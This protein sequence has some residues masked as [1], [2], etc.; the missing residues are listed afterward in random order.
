MPRLIRTIMVASM[1]FC[2]GTVAVGET[3]ESFVEP[4]RSVA[5]PASEMGVLAEIYVVE[6]D[7]VTKDQLVAKLNDDV[8]LASANVA[9]AAMESR[10]E[11]KL[12][13]AENDSRIDQ[14]SSYERLR[15]QGN[16]S[17]REVNRAINEKIKSA[18]KLQTARESQEVRRLEFARVQAQINLRKIKSPLSG[19]VVAIEKTVGEFVS[20]TDPVVMHI[21]ELNT[22]KVVFSVPRS[23]V[24]EIAVGQNIDL[25]VGFEAI[26]CQ[27]VVDF[28]SPIADPQ[29]GTVRVKI[30]ISNQD[31][32]LQSGSVCRWNLAAYESDTTISTTPTPKQR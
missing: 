29:S 23:A 14:L 9:R 30:R 11:L 10:G 19:H 4:Y 5:L 6:G 25:T 26:A 13:E 31:G 27:G 1:M 2:F 18:A 22:L 12:A 28:V 21:V 3:L 16:A 7:R 20:P 17:P 15:E 24:A 8:L 32:K